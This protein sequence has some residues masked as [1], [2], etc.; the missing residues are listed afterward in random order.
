MSEAIEASFAEVEPSEAKKPI[1]SFHLRIDFEEEG[2]QM[3][4][5]TNLTA[6]EQLGAIELWKANLLKDLTNAKAEE[7][8]DQ[9]V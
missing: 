2:M 3:H 6:L 8:K 1:R 5:N 7:E 9:N 4:V